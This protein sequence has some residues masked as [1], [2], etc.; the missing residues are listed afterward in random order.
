MSRSY[1]KTKIFG[2]AA[3]SEKSD[4]RR[5]NRIFRRFNKSMV[6]KDSD[7]LWF[8]MSEAMNVWSMA[9]DGKTYWRNASDKDMRK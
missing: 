4:K 5:A 9:K 8:N 6:K 7:K 3:T 2:I 1:R